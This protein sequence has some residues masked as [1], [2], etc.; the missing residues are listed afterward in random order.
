MSGGKAAQ[1]STI[2][3]NNNKRSRTVTVR[4]GGICRYL[5]LSIWDPIPYY[6][7]GYSH[8]DSDSGSSQRS[9]ENA[10][11]R[12]EKL[13]SP[14]RSADNYSRRGRGLLFSPTGPHMCQSDFFF[15]FLFSLFCFLF[16]VFFFPVLE[17]KKKR[18][19]KVLWTQWPL[20]LLSSR[21]SRQYLFTKYDAVR[22]V[23]L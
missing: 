13:H 5:F 3:T 8:S 11:E 22:P 1:T 7:F 20:A 6:P 23:I 15:R 16:S 4:K 19:E 17:K 14:G 2:T 18:K 21:A 9:R 12:K 10:R